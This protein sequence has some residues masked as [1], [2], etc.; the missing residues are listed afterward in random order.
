MRTLKIKG[1]VTILCLLGCFQLPAQHVEKLLSG[2]PAGEAMNNRFIFFGNAQKTY[3]KLFLE[4]NALVLKGEGTMNIVHIGDSHIQAGFI[5]EEMRKNFTA[6][7]SSGCGARG[8]VFPYRVAKTNNPS[9]YIVKFS[10]MWE[11]C[12]NVELRKSCS[13]GLTGIAIET[14]DSLAI[15]TYRFKENAVFREFNRVRIFH[16]PIDTSIRVDFPGLEGRYSVNPQQQV[17]FTDVVFDTILDSL[18]IRIEKRDTST[19]CFRL[20]GIDFENGDPGIVYSAAGVNGAEV[21]S[22]LRCDQLESQLRILRPDW[23]ILS[24]GTNDAYPIHFDKEQFISGYKALITNI[25]KVDPGLPVLLTVPGDSYRRRRHDNLNLVEAREGIFQVAK[26]TNCAVWDFYTIMG[27]PK[28]IMHWYRAGLVAKD[29][30]H[31]S[32][33]GYIIQGDL[34]FGAFM[35]AYSSFIDTSDTVK[36]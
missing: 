18:M 27:G 33:Q 12:R 32:K 13:L 34:L 11:S 23:V 8:L 4:L 31:F 22:F 29:K 15:M 14:R 3:E 25:R 9:D 30:L 7:I 17:G 10:G 36:E 16:D 2:V 28:S 19:G 5:P 26:E 1:L 24:L 21:S 6:Y 35:D 20:Y